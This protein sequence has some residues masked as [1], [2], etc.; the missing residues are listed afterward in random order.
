MNKIYK[1]LWIFLPFF[2]FAQNRDI[3]IELIDS[4]KRIE[5]DEKSL[6]IRPIHNLTIYK[7]INN[8]YLVKRVFIEIDSIGRI[9]LNR[10]P[11]DYQ[12]DINNF[13]R[14]ISTFYTQEK[15]Y[16][17]PGEN[18]MTIIEAPLT[19]INHQ[20]I[21]ITIQFQDDVLENDKHLLT[22]TSYSWGKAYYY[23]V[24]DYPI[25]NYLNESEIQ[26]LQKLLDLEN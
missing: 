25:F 24:N 15:L 14:E 3:P 2:S 4:T 23:K 10:N 7:C 9:F 13:N 6:Q 26:I 16:K 1:F 22:K 12:F 19:E 20:N 21:L 11:T 8:T 17:S 18:R 5:K